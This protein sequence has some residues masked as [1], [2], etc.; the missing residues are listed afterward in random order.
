MELLLIRHGQ[1]A[2]DPHAHYQ[3]PVTGC[4]S[5]KGQAQAMRMAQNLSDLVITS[6]YASPLGRALQTAQ[7]IAAPRDLP[8][9]VCPFLE[10][11]RP[12]EVLIQRQARQQAA[13]SGSTDVQTTIQP[14]IV[15]QQYR[16][17]VAWKTPL[18]EGT[19]EMAARLIPPFLNLLQQHDCTPAHGGYLLDNP[20]DSQRIAI[21]AHGGTLGML[22]SFL[23]GLP[24]KPYSPISFCETGVARL[25]FQL[26][27][28]VY[29]PTLLIPTPTP[30]SDR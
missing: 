23:L 18:G 9:E 1:I 24:L 10:E 11:W 3:P 22:L 13:H 27:V 30:D 5:Q 15:D 21:V 20:D 14:T 16:P 17:E 8:I 7:A 26:H 29:Y 6:I 4:L 28:D 12:A 2:G 25:R 19:Y